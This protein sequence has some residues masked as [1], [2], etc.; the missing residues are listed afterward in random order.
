M[1]YYTRPTL[2][3]RIMDGVFKASRAT[4]F[5]FSSPKWGNVRCVMIAGRYL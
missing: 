5:S 4:A 2:D 3:G 1:K